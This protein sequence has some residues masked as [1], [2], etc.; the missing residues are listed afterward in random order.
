[1]TEFIALYRGRTVSDAQLVALSAE[2]E[3][4]QRFFDELRGR[5]EGTDRRKEPVERQRL[6]VVPGAE[7]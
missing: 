5:Y 7:E 3:V 1:M 4:V 2:P 6:E